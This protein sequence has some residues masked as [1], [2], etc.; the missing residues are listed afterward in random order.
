MKQ[1]LQGCCVCCGPPHPPLA[2]EVLEDLSHFQPAP[3]TGQTL[4][5]DLLPAFVCDHLPV[6]LH[7]NQL[8]NG[9]YVVPLLQVTEG[10]GRLKGH[11]LA[12]QQAFTKTL[13]LYEVECAIDFIYGKT[14]T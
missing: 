8:G 12:S 6:L 9:R 10:V 4:V 7:D 11:Q 14:S 1:S 5:S 13:G 3:E 2:F